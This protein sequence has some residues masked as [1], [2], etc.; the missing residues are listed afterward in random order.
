M[1]RGPEQIFFQVDTDHRQTQ[2]KLFN[3][4]NQQGKAN[5]NH[6][7]YHFTPFRMDIIK[8]DQHW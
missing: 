1:N 2:E 3:V 5:Q 6:N 4:T 8:K 7:K